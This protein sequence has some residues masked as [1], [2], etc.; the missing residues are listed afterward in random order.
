MKVGRHHPRT[1][2]YNR[3]T[4]KG[5]INGFNCYDGECNKNL[6]CFWGAGFI[7]WWKRDCKAKTCKGG[8]DKKVWGE[9]A[10]FS[11]HSMHVRTKREKRIAGS[12][13]IHMHWRKT[14]FA[15]TREIEL[16]GYMKTEGGIYRRWTFEKRQSKKGVEE[17]ATGS[18]SQ[19]QEG[20]VPKSNKVQI[21]NDL[22]MTDGLGQMGW[23]DEWG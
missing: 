19:A 16:S 18:S 11:Y 1:N 23:M 14:F 2:G 15:W 17:Q 3:E 9:K 8:Y 21:P 12:C 5:F 6:N 20:N 13:R 7:H 4:F 22:L 10:A